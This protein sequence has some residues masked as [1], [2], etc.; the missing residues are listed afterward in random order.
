MDKAAL[1]QM[2]RARR[3]AL[4][5][6]EL[7]AAGGRA[8]DVLLGHACWTRARTV[9]L[10]V[11]VRG[12]L[13][14][15][16]VIAAARATGKR[17]ALPRT[18]PDGRME[19][20]LAGADTPMA[21]GAHGI[22]EPSADAPVVTPAELDLVLAP[23]LAFD[24]DGWR[25]GQGGGDYDRLLAAVSPTCVAIGWCHAF[26]LVDRVPTEPHDRRVAWVIT[27]EGAQGTAA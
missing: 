9:A 1:R 3:Q 6:P 15:A 13:P 18:G 20:R 24:R 26:Q 4:G 23:G 17:V 11:A 27:P 19:L 8:A 14:T 16:A 21:T 2:L 10:H 7:A 5:A 12:E 22:P 25:L